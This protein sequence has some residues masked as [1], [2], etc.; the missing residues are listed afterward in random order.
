MSNDREPTRAKTTKKEEND[1]N[2]ANRKPDAPDSKASAEV[3]NSPYFI[4]DDKGTPKKKG[5][6][7]WLNHF[8]AR[9]L[10]TLFKCSIAVWIATLLFL[11]NPTLVAY[12]QATFFGCIVLFI[13]PCNGIVFVHVMGGLTMLVGMAAA[14][15]WG[16]ISMKAALATRSTAETDARLAQLAAQATQQQ[17]NT[18]QTTGQSNYTQVLIFEGF[19]LDARVTITYFCMIG[20]FIYLVARIRVAAPKLALLQVFAIIISDIFLTIGPLLPTFSGIIPSVLVKPAATA[21][22]IG[23]VCNILFFPQSTSHLV[24]EAMVGVVAPMKGFLSACKLSFRDSHAQ[25]DLA[26]LQKTKSDVIA[27]YKGMEASLGFLTLDLSIG[28]WSTEDV[29]SL[30]EPLRQLVIM[31]VGLLQLQIAHVESKARNEKL[32]LLDEVMHGGNNGTQRPDI[33]QNHLVQVLSLR[34]RVRH[35]ESE[36]LLEKSMGALFTS[37]GPLLETCCDVVDTITEAVQ[38]VNNRRWFK[39]PRM[40]DCIELRLEH[41]KVLKR[42]KENQEQFETLASAHLLNPHVHLFDEHGH[43]K[44]QS[45]SGAPVHG[46]LLGLI[47]AERILGVASA[48]DTMLARITQLEQARTKTKVWF[49]MGLRKLFSWAVGSDVAPGVAPVSSSNG[50]T[51][52]QRMVTQNKSNSS[53]RKASKKEKGQ[54]AQEQLD[55]LL[56]HGGRKRSSFGKIL[57][58]VTH[59]LGNTEGMFALRMLIVTIALAL[60]AVLT[61]SAGFFY[62]E[63]GL[64]AVIMA[65]TGLLPY[66]ADFVYGFILR[67]IG[68]VVGG[69][70]G[71]VCW[72]I[73]AGSGPGNPYGMAAIMALA[74]VVLMWGRLFA[75]LALLQGVLLMASTMYLVVAYSWVDTHIPSYGNPGVGYSVFWRRTLLVLIGFTASAIVIFV[76]RPP[77]ASRHYRRVLARTIRS[78]KDLYALY[79]KSWS[80]EYSGLQETFEKQTLANAEALGAIAGPIGM[81]KF[82]FSSSNFD[83][84]TLTHVTRL[85][86]TINQSLMQMMLYA[87]LLSPDLKARFARLSSALDDRFTGDLMAVLTLAEQSLKTGD[88]LP[89]IL[90]VPLIAR[91]EGL[92]KAFAWEGAGEGILSIESIRGTGFGKYCVVLSAF[93]QLLG[94]ADELVWRIKTAVGETS[95]VDVEQP[96]LSR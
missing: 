69:I 1:E 45:G 23:M 89:A 63:K 8:N 36:D 30:H 28:R 19:M 74:I 65:Q 93:I 70:L 90:P 55:Q 27:G 26:Q 12:G 84:E 72:Y 87:T 59:W 52:Q 22:G 2:A 83:A 50:G 95:Y 48:L 46:L 21:V 20:L 80:H 79:V 29:Q 32:D 4:H 57:L 82:E 6:P 10:K 73:G 86:M 35:P 15:A 76:P 66:T 68:T 14:W 85:C 25:F 37:S 58:A 92:N 34:N 62:R 49:P 71:M 81:L 54:G 24:L 91:C 53:H 16:V 18:E 3:T 5:L 9:D 17:S 96:F 41:E 40:D 43:L 44:A 47:F 33:G 64:W 13:V 56:F 61:S 38:T 31:F 11:I 51:R 39:K 88:A 78:N 77:S 42:L 67:T 75:P 7:G 60:P 94:A